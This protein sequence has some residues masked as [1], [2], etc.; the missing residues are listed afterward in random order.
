MH[1]LFQQIFTVC[2]VTRRS[3]RCL[4]TWTLPPFL[5]IFFIF[6]FFYFFK[7]L[8]WSIIASQW[9]VSFCFITKWISYRYTH[10]PISPPSRISLPPTLPIPPTQAV[11]KHSA[12]LPVLCGCFPLALYFTFGSVYMSM[13]LSHPVK[14]KFCRLVALSHKSGFKPQLTVT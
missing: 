12:D 3:P 6:Y 8:Y 7:H 10:V 4:V 1:L 2:S 11:T 14:Q 9:C 13:T 5:F